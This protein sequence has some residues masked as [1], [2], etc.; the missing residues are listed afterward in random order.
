MDRNKR[1]G[2]E[3]STRFAAARVPLEG[4]RGR[5]VDPIVTISS[6]R[7]RKVCRQLSD[8]YTR[9]FSIHARI[10]LSFFFFFDLSSIVRR[11]R[12]SIEMRA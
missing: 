1:G 2:R 8:S 4:G 9:I 5:I 6:L 3:I 7:L 10:D 11:I 12:N